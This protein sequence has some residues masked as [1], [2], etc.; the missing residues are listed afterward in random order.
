PHVHHYQQF[1]KPLAPI[2]W[3][4]VFQAIQPRPALYLVS[5]AIH[6]S[7]AQRASHSEAP[8]VCRASADAQPA[9]SRTGP[10]NSLNEMAQSGRIQFKWVEATSG[11]H[12]QADHIRGFDDGTL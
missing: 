9:C 2:W 3:N 8:V 5:L 4:D 10:G 6:K 12:R 11:K 7:P 1:F